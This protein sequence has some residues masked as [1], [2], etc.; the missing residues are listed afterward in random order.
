MLQFELAYLDF[1]RRLDGFPNDLG[2]AYGLMAQYNIVGIIFTKSLPLGRVLR[3]SLSGEKQ[4]CAW[5]EFQ[6]LVYT[7]AFAK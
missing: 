6:E 4:S 3:A 7:V 2:S 1:L 5:E